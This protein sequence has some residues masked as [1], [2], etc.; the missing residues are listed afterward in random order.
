MKERPTESLTGPALGVAVYGF[1]TQVGV[2][3]VVAAVLAVLF[4]F[5]P[6][7]ISRFVDAWRGDV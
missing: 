3:H 7:A 6:I 1:A 4:A 2:P 5:G